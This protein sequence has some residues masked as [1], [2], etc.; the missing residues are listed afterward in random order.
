MKSFSELGIEP[1]STGFKGKKIPIEMIFDEEITV[2][3]FDIRDSIIPEYGNTKCLYLQI[4]FKGIQRV[5]F[6][7]SNGLMKTLE[8]VPKEEFPFTATITK[9]GERYEFR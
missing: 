2:Q 1:V 4:E 5:V 9:Q 8:R 3:D 7:S 6:T